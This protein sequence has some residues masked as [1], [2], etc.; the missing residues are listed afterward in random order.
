MPLVSMEKFTP[1][2]DGSSFYYG[3][4]ECELLLPDNIPLVFLRYETEPP[5]GDFLYSIRIGE[6]ILKKGYNIRLFWGR[7]LVVSSCGCYLAV[8]EY[9]RTTGSYSVFDLIN[10]KEWRSK[11]FVTLN[12]LC[13]PTLQIQPLLAPGG[14][15][16]LGEVQEVNLSKR[17]TWTQVSTSKK[18]EPSLYEW[19]PWT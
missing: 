12:M 1:K 11:G 19:P 16:E 6:G 5:H 7:N 9:T 15:V 18:I 8:T 2:T 13:Y 10:M 4:T 14:N 17:R 3:G